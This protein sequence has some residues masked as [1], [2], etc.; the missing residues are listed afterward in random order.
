M[1]FEDIITNPFLHLP[2]KKSSQD[3]FRTFLFKT[4]DDYLEL[5]GKITEESFK[6]D[7]LSGT[8]KISN[9]I[10][11]Q[12]EF[13]EGLKD[14]LNFYLNG[15]PSNSYQKFSDT[16]D[17]RAKK[18]KQIFNI[19]SFD[20]DQNFYRIRIKKE[21]FA[22]NQT[23]MFHIPF[24][25]RNRVN[26]Q[27]YSIPGFPSLYLSKTLY[28]A[29]EE[30]KRPS[31]NNFQAVRLKSVQKIKYLDL[32]GSNISNNYYSDIAYKYLMTW[33]LI[34]CCSVKVNNYDDSFKPEY[35]FPQLLLQWIRNNKDI[36]AIKYNSTHISYDGIE[37]K[38]DLYNLVLPVKENKD[39][40]HCEELLSMFE[41]TSTISNQLLE[42]S[43][44]GMMFFESDEQIRK[45]NDKI[46]RI[47]FI[48]GSKSPYGYSILG[49]IERKLD[50]MRTKEI[51]SRGHINS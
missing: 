23:E 44:G 12:S 50:S 6:I 37:T 38:G 17:N 20:T 24:E 16:L 9:T 13:I 39:V 28:V 29:W 27:R 49:K 5:L 8:K 46:P 47:E 35:I 22:L 41:M 7:G 40:G 2:L 25:L 4:L 33:P 26:T 19:N 36:D 43:S 32:T 11:I 45:I 10:R 42:F 15:Q 1:T 18:Y 30:L 31:V 21:N 34:A 14:T 51:V 48:A 3:S